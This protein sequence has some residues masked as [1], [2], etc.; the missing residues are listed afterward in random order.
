MSSENIRKFIEEY[1]VNPELQQKLKSIEP[2][3]E[4]AFNKITKEAGFELTVEEWR[5]YAGQEGESRTEVLTDDEL[6]GISGGLFGIDLCQKKYDEFLCKWSWCPQLRS[7]EL[8]EFR[9]DGERY[10]KSYATCYFCKLGY[11]DETDKIKLK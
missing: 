4:A 5:K 2:S 7:K 6:A 10:V 3:D 8:Y 11:W 9:K 1:K